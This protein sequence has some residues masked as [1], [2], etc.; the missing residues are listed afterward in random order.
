MCSAEPDGV[1]RRRREN[2]GVLALAVGL[3]AAASTPFPNPETKGSD[4]RLPK[5][6][7]RRPGGPCVLFLGVIPSMPQELGPSADDFT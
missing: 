5:A 7:K 1:E 4:D 3:W 2:C 6:I